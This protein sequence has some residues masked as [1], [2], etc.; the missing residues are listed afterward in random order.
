MNPY[1]DPRSTYSVMCYMLYNGTEEDGDEA[2]VGWVRDYLY[3]H[4]SL[5]GLLS[6]SLRNE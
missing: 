4:S 5:T 2:P 3:D 1:A 6:Y